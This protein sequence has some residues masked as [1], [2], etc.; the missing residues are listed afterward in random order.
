MFGGWACIPW[1]TSSSSLSA[2][3]PSITSSVAP[4]IFPVS[5]AF[6][7]VSVSISAP[8]VVFIGRALF[9]FLYLFGFVV[10][11]FRV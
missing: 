3:S 9:Y 4:S 7:S 2:H 10:G 11:L 6:S 5:R 1:R 8:L